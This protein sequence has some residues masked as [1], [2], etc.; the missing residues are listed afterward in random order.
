MSV[1]LYRVRCWWNLLESAQVYIRI[2]RTLSPPSGTPGY[3]LAEG[4]GAFEPITP[5]R[6][7]DDVRLRRQ[8]RIGY[9]WAHG[10]AHSGGTM[11]ERLRLP[12]TDGS[13]KSGRS[14][15]LRGPGRGGLLEKHKFRTARSAEE[16]SYARALRS[17][18]PF[19][20]EAHSDA[21]CPSIWLA[22]LNLVR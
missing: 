13:A 6:M 21:G 10:R 14:G 4:L 12:N 15:R 7:H 11:K 2:H 8:R 17:L 3:V 18:N 20:P 9:A 22:A 16:W 5:P 1:R 19:F